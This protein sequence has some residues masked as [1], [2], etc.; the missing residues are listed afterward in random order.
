MFLIMYV[1]RSLDTHGVMMSGLCVYMY[2]GTS[3]NPTLTSGRD[4]I[5]SLNP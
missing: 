4:L 3:A 1:F 5:R 2:I